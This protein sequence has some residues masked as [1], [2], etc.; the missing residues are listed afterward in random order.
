MGKTFS[1][2]EFVE[3]LASGSLAAPSVL[4]GMVKPAEDDPKSLLFATGTS[5]ERW[6]PI[7]VG[8]IEQVEWLGTVGCRDH[9]HD[10]VRLTLKEA[11]SAEGTVLA[12]LLGGY[13]ESR[14]LPSPAPAMPSQPSVAAPAMDPRALPP[15]P[16]APARRVEQVANF[17]RAAPMADPAAPMTTM[18]ACW[19][20][21]HAC[22]PPDPFGQRGCWYC[23][24]GSWVLAMRAEGPVPCGDS[25]HFWCNGE[26]RPVWNC[27][28]FA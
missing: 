8:M 5:C 10:Y 17:R 27:G 6:V 7:P 12:S 13:A 1:G 23:C 16:T 2:A 18:S 19:E 15:P 3:A 28:L 11:T 14:A 20:G 21:S 22:G 25:G 9:T 24:N 26:W 4:T